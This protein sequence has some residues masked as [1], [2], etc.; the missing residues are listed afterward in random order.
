MRKEKEILWRENKYEVMAHSQNAYRH[1]QKEINA[2]SLNELAN[3]IKEAKEITSTKG[4]VINT[5]QHIWGYFKKK[6]SQLE[7]EKTF[8]LLR[9]YEEEQI[10]EMLLW[11]WLAKLA[12]K[13]E[14]TYL[15]QSTLIVKHLH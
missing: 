15:L 11:Q 13:Y 1:I 9:K 10:K 6:A 2:I 12:E 8:E 7:K 5:Y 3:L 4:S 14:E